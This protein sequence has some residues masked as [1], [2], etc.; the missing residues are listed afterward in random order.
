MAVHGVS[1]AEDPAAR[2]LLG[3]GVVDG[4]Q[5]GRRDLHRQVGI[6]DEVAD[7]RARGLLVDPRRRLL[8]V[9]T[10]HQQP[11]VPRADHPDQ[12]HADAP[13]VRAG[14]EDPVQD[15]RTVGA[16]LGEVGLEDDVHAA[17]LGHATGEGQ[18]ELLGDRAAP[19]VGADQVAG[20]D[21][22]LVASD[23]VAQQRGD[24]VLVL[25]EADELGVEADLGAAGRRV[26][27]ED[28]LQI[29]LRQ[30]DHLAGALGGV[31][32]GRRGAGAPAADAADL[33]ARQGRAQHGVP[34]QVRGAAEGQR[35][36]LDA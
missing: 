31:L 4:P 1:C 12:A 29:G 22:E 30:V 14:L 26:V 3:V 33:V 8:Y 18:A 36:R 23:P 20:A 25:F 28:R 15:A 24:S 7:D 2:V 11:L 9:V 5:R 13:R 10:P 32:G 21:R 34:H 35:L 6:A 17:G 19:A 16:V 27:D